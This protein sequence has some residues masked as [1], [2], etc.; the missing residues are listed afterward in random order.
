M[1]THTHRRVRS[2]CSS[3]PTVANQ[4]PKIIYELHLHEEVG[5]HCFHKIQ[6]SGNPVRHRIL[7]E[8][9]TT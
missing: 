5:N 1:C 4:L 9:D 8:M 3:A 2:T 6:L 7:S